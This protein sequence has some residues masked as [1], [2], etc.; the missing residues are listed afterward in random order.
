MSFPHSSQAHL[1]SGKDTKLKE[2]PS[3]K[4]VFI[5]RNKFYWIAAP[6]DWVS[7]SRRFEGTYRF[8]LQGQVRELTHNPKDEGGTFFRNVGKQLPNHTAQGSERQFNSHAVEPSNH[9]FFNIVRNI[10]ISDYC[11]ASFIE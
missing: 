2:V 3:C 11:I 7:V 8:H 5:L 1:P 4:L 10:F 6:C 9:F